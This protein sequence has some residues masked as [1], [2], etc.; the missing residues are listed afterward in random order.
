MSE[1]QD[2]RKTSRD[3]ANSDPQQMRAAKRLKQLQREIPI[4][5]RLS[6]WRTQCSVRLVNH[7]KAARERQEPI[8]VW[9]VIGSETGWVSNLDGGYDVDESFAFRLVDAALTDEQAFEFVRHLA[10]VNVSQAQPLPEA[11]RLFS[12]GIV[13]G[14]YKSPAKASRPITNWYRDFCIIRAIKCAERFG[15][16]ATMNDATYGICGV[17]LVHEALS[18]VWQAPITSERVKDIWV[19]RKN[20]KKDFIDLECALGSCFN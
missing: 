6:N 12:A 16:S 3:S 14:S 2:K 8:S 20:F 4:G 5:E 9:E 1:H 10:S 7:L 11:L 19:K 18:E 17:T 15:I 13:S